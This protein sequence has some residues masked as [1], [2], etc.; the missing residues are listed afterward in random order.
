MGDRKAIPGFG[1]VDLDM[2]DDAAG[3][4]AATVPPEGAFGRVDLEVDSEPEPVPPS[5]SRVF[6]AEGRPIRARATSV[7][8]ESTRIVAG[9]ALSA[10][11]RTAPHHAHDDGATRAWADI[12]SEVAEA[13]A[14]PSSRNGNPSGSG[15][16][17]RGDDRVAAMRELYARGDAA[18]ALA[19]ASTLSHSVA[20][21]SNASS[22]D[23]PD[24][25]IVVEFGE[26][27]IDLSDPFG[28]LIPFADDDPAPMSRAS[29]T[30]TVPPPAAQLTLTERQ[31][32]PRRLT[33][34]ADMSK[35]KIDHRAGFLLAHIDG[36]QTLE[37][38]LDVC[39]MPAEEALALIANLKVLGVIEFE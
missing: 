13:D 12:D 39:A 15:V 35:L 22:A 6:N 31:S 37:E 4:G 14:P 10:M 34:L 16:A 7:H 8:D 21:P 32:I 30:A 24:A 20:L 33:A 18:G 5:T 1:H 38:L 28:G 29:A 36:M 3:R 9:D 2:G 25:S 11:T 17:A 27:S 23:S 19:L 26:Q